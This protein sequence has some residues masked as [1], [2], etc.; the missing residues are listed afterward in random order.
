MMRQLIADDAGGARSLDPR[1]RLL[2]GP[3]SVLIGLA[4][5]VVTATVDAVARKPPE[6]NR[7]DF[8]TF[9]QFITGSASMLSST[10]LG[11]THIGVIFICTCC[12]VHCLGMRNSTGVMALLNERL[13]KPWRQ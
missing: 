12:W 6:A 10:A 4:S 13:S 1:A 7:R 2:T 9:R 11:A 8:D 3:V 5:R